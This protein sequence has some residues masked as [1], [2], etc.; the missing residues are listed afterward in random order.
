MCVCVFWVLCL[1]TDSKWWGRTFSLILAWL[2]LPWRTKAISISWSLTQ[3]SVF[4][5]NHQSQWLLRLALV[6]LVHI[7]TQRL[8]SKKDNQNVQQAEDRGH[9]PLRSILAAVLD[10]PGR[11]EDG[12]G[13]GRCPREACTY[14]YKSI[15]M[16]MSITRLAGSAREES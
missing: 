14:K 3:C 6:P 4:P 8:K 1:E 7:R 10:A 15:S 2:P 16:T 11:G 12:W 13:G 5:F 9:R